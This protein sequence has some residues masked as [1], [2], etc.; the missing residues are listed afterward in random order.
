MHPTVR[1][2][3]FPGMKKGPVVV[4]CHGVGLDLHMWDQ[5]LPALTP[6]FQVVRYDFI[7]HGKTP[8]NPEVSNLGA[9]TRQ[10][11]ALLEH[12]GL[13]RITSS[14]IVDGWRDRAAIRCRPPGTS[15]PAGVDEHSLP[16]W[17]ERTGRG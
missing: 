6:D 10:L 9:F 15:D 7:G 1:G 4:L 3:K 14:R 12:L 13:E 5:Q 2:T 8:P 11:F 16:A 17:A